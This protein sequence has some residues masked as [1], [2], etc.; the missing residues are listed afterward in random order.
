[1]I[2]VSNFIWQDPCINFKISLKNWL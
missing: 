1:M 2:F